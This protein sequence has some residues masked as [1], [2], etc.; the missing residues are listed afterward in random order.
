VVTRTWLKTLGL[1][2]CSSAPST[3]TLQRPTAQLLQR[4]T[5]QLLHRPRLA[6]AARY[7]SRSEKAQSCGWWLEWPEVGLFPSPSQSRQSRRV[8]RGL[9]TDP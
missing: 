7:C 4:P 5:A 9:L 1:S 2:C 3:A 8:D 6:P